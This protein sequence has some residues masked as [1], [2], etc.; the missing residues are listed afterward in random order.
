MMYVCVSCA[1]CALPACV[2]MHACVLMQ[3]SGFR[4]STVNV[5]PSYTARHHIGVG[6]QMDFNM[7]GG[8]VGVYYTVSLAT[9]WD[10]SAVYDCPSGYHWASTAEGQEFFVGT[11]EGRGAYNPYPPA[12]G[13]SMFIP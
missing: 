8:D 4:R 3:C 11:P 6:G 10:P 5:G 12:Q 1:L 13:K 2:R 7:T 9:V